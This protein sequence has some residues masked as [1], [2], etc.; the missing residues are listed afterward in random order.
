MYDR[1]QDKL[2]SIPGFTFTSEN[3]DMVLNIAL[4]KVEVLIEEEAAEKQLTVREREEWKTNY[5]NSVVGDIREYFDNLPSQEEFNP[6]PPRL[7]VYVEN[8]P[9]QPVINL[10][11]VTTFENLDEVNQANNIIEFNEPGNV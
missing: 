3:L 11:S 8:L 5:I 7:G 10:G 9:E 1:V 2:A 4:D 6:P